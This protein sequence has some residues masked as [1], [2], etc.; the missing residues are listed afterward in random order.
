VLVAVPE[1]W[2]CA[3]DVPSLAV[4]FVTL[5]LPAGALVSA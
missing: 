5:M 1:S 2:T 3:V 4:T